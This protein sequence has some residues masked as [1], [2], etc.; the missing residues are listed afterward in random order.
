[1]FFGLLGLLIWLGW[2][3]HV[4]GWPAKLAARMV[5]LSGMPHEAGINI[6]RCLIAVLLTV[7]WLFAINPKR[8]NRAAVT[9]WAVGITMTWSLLMV[10]WLPLIDSARSYQS[11]F[12]GLKQH[13]PARF[14]CINSRNLPQAQQALMHYYTGIRVL[15]LETSPALACDFYL[16][17]D[18]RDQ[19]VLQPGADWEL[20]WQG[21]RPAE[22]KENLR[23]FRLK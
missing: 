21:K 13:L 7:L 20:V 14:A 10:L 16:I 17:R 15:P 22:R 9:E 6:A 18:Q 4:T 2:F 5:F 11:V 23:L 3:A 1:M 12:L 8:S 19:S